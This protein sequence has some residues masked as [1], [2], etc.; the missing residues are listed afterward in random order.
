M[1][2]Q[3]DLITARL[4]GLPPSVWRTPSVLPG[5]TITELAQHLTMSLRATHLVLA[6]PSPDKPIGIDRYVS[7]YAAADNLTF[8]GATVIALDESDAGDRP[9]RAGLLESLGATIRLK[10]ID[11][12]AA[13]IRAA[14]P[15]LKPK[16]SARRE[17]MRRAWAT[18]KSKQ[19]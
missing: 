14:F 17:A 2:A 4:S 8:L 9:E 1:I 19:E 15:S 5:W 3:A 12:E 11:Q 16:K 10:Q 13:R 18:R 6:D 7:G